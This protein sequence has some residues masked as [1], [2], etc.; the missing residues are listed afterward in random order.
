MLLGRRRLLHLLG[1]SSGWLAGSQLIGCSGSD[2]APQPAATPAPCEA[3]WWLC[4]NFAPVAEADV[5]ELEVIGALPPS[6]Q[7]VFLRNGPNPMSGTSGHWFVG[8][9]MVHG[10][11]LEGGR[12][13]WYRAKYVQTE[14]LGVEGEGSIGPPT[15]TGHQAN[16]SLLSHDG[17]VLCLCEVGIPYA[18]SPA[19]LSTSGPYDFDGQLTGSMTAHPKVDPVTGEIIFFGYDFLTP[20]I[21]CYRLAPNGTLREETI[22]LPAAVMMHEFQ[23]TESHIVLMDLPLLFD[24]D[25]AVAGI[26][27][28][29]AW[30]PQNGARIGVMPRSGT[31]ADLE[32]F[33]IDPCFIFHTFNAFVD[34]GKVS[35]DAVRYPTMWTESPGQL[36]PEGQWWRYTMTLGGGTVTEEQM[37]EPILE[38]PRIDARMQGRGHRF[39]YALSPSAGPET[40]GRSFD[41]FVKFDLR[42]GKA[43]RVTVGGM[44]LDEL[45]FV[46]DSASA[47]EDEGWL[48]GFAWDP[49]ADK[50][51]LVVFDASA[52]EAG[53]VAQVILPARVPHGFHGTFVPG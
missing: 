42:S 34:N 52:P 17:Q 13:P 46:P 37:D 47:G 16:T 26:S 2:P 30:K 51:R 36:D 35:L 50:S 9:G 23:I 20:S 12:A 49:G 11:R 43:D 14:I 10:V 6:L 19:D 44:H 5:G 27:M 39:G 21:R 24:I 53:P 15:L 29:F 18:I 41:S 33:D 7:G 25:M 22:E 3:D 32:W 40:L 48:C 45:T 38:F 8:D 4:G 31:A 1:S 28:P